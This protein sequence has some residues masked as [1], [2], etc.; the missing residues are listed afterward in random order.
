MARVVAHPE[1][2]WKGVPTGARVALLL[3]KTNLL[4]DWTPV[5]ATADQLRATPG[6]ACIIASALH[7]PTAVA[8]H[9][10]R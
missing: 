7:S 6:I 9:W 1:G 2:G 8:Y 5:Y 3:N 10:Q 4:R